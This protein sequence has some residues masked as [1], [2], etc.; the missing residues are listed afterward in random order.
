MLKGLLLLVDL[1]IRLIIFLLAS[2]G[3]FLLRELV[4]FALFA[5]LSFEFDVFLID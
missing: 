4:E 2:S 1:D 3:K 5:A